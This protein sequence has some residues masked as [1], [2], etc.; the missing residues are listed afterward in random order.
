M[1]QI[2][3]VPQT[4][5]KF[6]VKQITSFL[7]SRQFKKRVKEFLFAVVDDVVTL[8]YNDFKKKQQKR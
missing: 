2:L 8:A 3:K 1:G 6:I 5:F 4:V 7:T